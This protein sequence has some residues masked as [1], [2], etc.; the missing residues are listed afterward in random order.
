MMAGWSP[1]YR[2]RASTRTLDPNRQLGNVRH[3]I[4]GMHCRAREV[5]EL[6]CRGM[7]FPDLSRYVYG[8]ALPEAHILN[9]GWLSKEHPYQRGLSPEW[10]VAHLRER[11]AQ[12]VNLYRG[13][14]ACEFCPDPSKKRLA[15]GAEIP[16]CPDDTL[17]NGE[18]RVRALDGKIYVAPVLILHYIG[19]HEYLPPRAFIEAVAA[20]LPQPMLR[21]GVWR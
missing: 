11:I 5:G 4:C 2:R 12:P 21:D 19:C 16:D 1:W 8:Q 7:Y 3:A 20:D 6:F 18:I 10:L 17:G 15:G 9:V 13:K 14:H